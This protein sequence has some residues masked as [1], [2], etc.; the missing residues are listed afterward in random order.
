MPGIRYGI[1]ERGDC[2]TTY[3]YGMDDCKTVFTLVHGEK[4]RTYESMYERMK[5]HTVCIWVALAGYPGGIRGAFRLG[6]A[7][8]SI[9]HI[10]L[11]P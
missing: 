9:S 2:E 10:R 8:H 6:L 1:D 3:A 11:D 5:A 7:S 4:G